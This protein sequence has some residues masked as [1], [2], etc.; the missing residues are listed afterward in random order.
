M[1]C[2]KFNTRKKQRKDSKNEK[3]ELDTIPEKGKKKGSTS[4][5]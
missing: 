4:K 2:N 5:K 1:S 3:P